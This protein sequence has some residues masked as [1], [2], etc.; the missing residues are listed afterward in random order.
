MEHH[1]R[2]LE[3]PAAGWSLPAEV[4]NL[5]GVVGRLVGQLEPLPAAIERLEVKMDAKFDRLEVR[6]DSLEQ[7]R[8]T[9]AGA[10]GARNVSRATAIAWTT[11]ALAFGG[12]VAAVV[13]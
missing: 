7:L 6:V 9:D 1:D 8:D 4:A 13:S 11:T 10:R 12:F 2:D 5:A 3:T